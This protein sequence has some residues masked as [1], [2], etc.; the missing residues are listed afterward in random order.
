[1][2]PRLCSIENDVIAFFFLSLFFLSLIAGTTHSIGI[3]NSAMQRVP[4]E[5]IPLENMAANS[6]H[7]YDVEDKTED[8]IPL[9]D[10]WGKF[11]SLRFRQRHA[12]YQNLDPTEKQLVRKEVHRID[13]FRD[14]FKER[15]LLDSDKVPLVTLLADSRAAWNEAAFDHC[16]SKLSREDISH[17]SLRDRSIL[18]AVWRRQ[19]KLCSEGELPEPTEEDRIDLR[20]YEPDEPDYGYNG[21]LMVFEDGRKRKN[22]PRCYGEFPHQK[23]SIRKLLYDKSNS[24]LTRTENKNELRYFHLPANNMAWVEVSGLDTITVEASNAVDDSKPYRNTTTRRSWILVATGS[25]L[26]DR[27]PRGS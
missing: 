2:S 4:E 21:W 26:L 13:F 11:M 5:S 12:F 19:G 17:I 23:I 7:P 16:R 22:D 18:E 3:E 27:R 8:P 20:N 15:R 1:M 25:W 10:S 6:H 24:P 14:N 9:T